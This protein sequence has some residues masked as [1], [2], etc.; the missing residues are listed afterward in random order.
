MSPRPRSLSAGL[1]GLYRKPASITGRS[2][3]PGTPAPPAFVDVLL[4][5]LHA[6]VDAEVTQVPGTL[7]TGAE[8][9]A[10]GSRAWS[11]GNDTRSLLLRVRQAAANAIAAGFE[12]FYPGVSAR[13]AVLVQALNEG[14]TGF[15]TGEQPPS[16]ARRR[17]GRGLLAEALCNRLLRSG[18]PRDA[19]LLRQLVPRSA[20]VEWSGVPKTA[21]ER[22][23]TTSLTASASVSIAA[24]QATHN[25]SEGEP[26]SY[27]MAACGLT[28]GRHQWEFKLLSHDT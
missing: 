15:V 7:L 8:E 2:S 14:V 18:D 22:P 23:V 24:M 25:S 3:S 5:T 9:L 28:S 4:G 27:A 12:T 26:F 13:H 17:I 6:L 20:G 10:Q 21:I 11:T 1:V 19:A 16:D